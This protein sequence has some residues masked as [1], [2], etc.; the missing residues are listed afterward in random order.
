M[1][2]LIEKKKNPIIPFIESV[3]DKTILILSIKLR[4]N[5]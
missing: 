3:F 2:I 5:T 1:R 4:S